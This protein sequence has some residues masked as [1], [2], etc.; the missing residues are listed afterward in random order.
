MVEYLYHK[1]QGNFIVI[2]G[3]RFRSIKIKMEYLKDISMHSYDW[4]LFLENLLDKQLTLLEI[5][6]RVFGEKRSSALEKAIW[7]MLEMALVKHSKLVQEYLES[8]THKCFGQ[9]WIHRYAYF[10][11]HGF[12]MKKLGFLRNKFDCGM[13]RFEAEMQ[14]LIEQM[15]YLGK[16][17]IT[18]TLR[19]LPLDRYVADV[20][21]MSQGWKKITLDYKQSFALHKDIRTSLALICDIQEALSSKRS[22]KGVANHFN[23][24]N[25]TV[26]MYALIACQELFV[27][28]LKKELRWQMLNNEEI[29]LGKALQVHIDQEANLL[30]KLKEILPD[31]YDQLIGLSSKYQYLQAK[32]YRVLNR[33]HVS[34]NVKTYCFGYVQN[35][36]WKSFSIELGELVNDSIGKD[37][38]IYAMHRAAQ[39]KDGSVVQKT[40]QFFKYV[41]SSLNRFN[42]TATGILESD[43]SVYLSTYKKPNAVRSAKN[44]IA[45]F[46][47]Y[48][49]NQRTIEGQ[50]EAES[51]K[52]I[53]KMIAR[54]FSVKVSEP[55]NPTMPLPEEVYLVIRLY[56]DEL[57]AEI[58]NAFLVI[59]ATGCRPSEIGY[60]EVDS[61][62]YDKKI[63]CYILEIYAN[64][65]VKAYAKRG[66]K[67]IR[68]VPIYDEEVIQAFHE[69][70]L[71]SKAVRMESGSHA[72]FIRRNQNRAHQVKYHIPSTRELTKP[73]NLL[74]EKYKI[75]ADLEADIWKYT[76][77][78]MRSMI[79][80]AMVEKGHAPEE[81]KAF[82][83]WMSI[84]TP[85]KAYAYIR[86]RKVEEL[87]TD[88]FRKHFKVSLDEER[89]QAYTREEKEQLFIEL[90]VHKRKMEY[91]ECVRHPIMGEC[92]KLQAVESCASCARMITDVPYLKTWIEFRD[93]QKNILDSIVIEMEA[94]GISS[95]EYATWAEY[96][97]QQHRLESYQSVVDEL[98]VEKE[99]RCQH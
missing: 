76:P 60:I 13:D 35:N 5:A 72:I 66:K 61:L 69:Q 79:A 71:L 6:E 88:L 24:A 37:L 81:I 53:Q 63:G 22:L 42:V 56:L 33:I 39:N 19:I 92:G 40:I 14:H 68:K 1:K 11:Y 96:I 20:N 28:A 25:S 55:E 2:N 62:V 67:P 18:L 80:T 44:H 75:K 65:Q 31:F 32:L 77:Y 99:R 87:N 46:Y 51:L 70:V 47:T 30:Y 59:S 49:S 54:D 12:N 57:E 26:I 98:E 74:I 23:V 9:Y 8:H 21:Y 52:K 41:K 16:N 84:H 38:K 93:N 17:D 45:S 36:K 34:K 58:K 78:Q 3:E 83:G 29:S 90:Y 82:F 15:L 94:E 50:S 89:L 97:I 43:V 86:E 10:E 85:E 73:I 7:T 95:R 91:G 64:K 48:L 4:Y 27:K